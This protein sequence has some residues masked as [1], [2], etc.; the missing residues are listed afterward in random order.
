MTHTSPAGAPPGRVLGA[1]TVALLRDAHGRPLACTLTGPDSE[2]GTPVTVA[3]GVDQVE[4]L[5]IAGHVLDA[6]MAV[7]DA[8][9]GPSPHHPAAT[10]HQ[11]ATTRSR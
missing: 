5:A 7:L 10:R 6:A 2:S 3:L 9:P 4:L 11:S 1:V 8:G